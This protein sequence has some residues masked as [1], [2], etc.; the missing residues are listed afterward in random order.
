MLNNVSLVGRITKDPILKK[1]TMLPLQD[2]TFFELAINTYNHDIGKKE[3]D[4]IDCIA[5]DKTAAIICKYCGKGSVI[6][7]KG[8]LKNNIKQYEDIRIKETKVICEQITFIDL[9]KRQDQINKNIK[10]TAKTDIKI[11]DEEFAE[12]QKELDQMLK[13]N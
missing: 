4:F 8:H 10:K 5:F 1:T 2:A 11:S 3:A 6:A 12:F 9:K 13:G 7:I